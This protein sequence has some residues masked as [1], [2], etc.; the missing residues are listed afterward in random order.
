MHATRS[1]ENAT[2]L[3]AKAGAE[4]KCAEGSRERRLARTSDAHGMILIVRAIAEP[5]PPIAGTGPSVNTS[6]AS[7]IRIP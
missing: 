6:A 7:G 2:G 4:G 3:L 5:A 1:Q